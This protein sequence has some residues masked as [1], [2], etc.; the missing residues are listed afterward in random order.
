MESSTVNPRAFVSNSDEEIVISG[1]SGRFP[2]A[3][4][5]YE[6]SHNLYNKI[7]MVDDEETRWRHA[8][9]E[10]PKLSGKISGLER[11]DNNFFGIPSKQ[12]QSMDPQCRMM[13]E[14]A[15]EA[16]LDS[17]T[18]PI[19]IRGTKTGV[20]VG[21]CYSESEKT[22]FYEKATPDGS[23]LSG[24]SRALLA[25]RISFVLGLTGP[26]LICDT[27]CSSS[28][29]ALDM[30]YN[31]IKCG[32]CDA[33]FVGGTNLVL[34]P[35]ISLQFARLGVL[36]M[37]G[38]CSPFDEKASGYT[39]SETTAII[40]LQKM[41]NARR[42]YGTLMYSKSNC[43][44]FKEEGIHYPSGNVQLKL[45]DEFYKDLNIS[46]SSVD[47]IEAHCTG[48]VAGDPE[49]C[50]A[51]SEIFCKD[52]KKPKL[53]GSIKSNLGHTEASSG[54]CSIVKVITIFENGKIP[55][56]INYNSPRID[57]PSL[58][59]GQLKV[60]DEVTDFNGSLICVNSFGFGGANSHALFKKNP[61]SKVNFGIPNDDIPRLV[62]WSG[63]TEEAVNEI[64]DSITEKPLDAE[65]IALLQHSQTKT[66]SANFYK[67]YGIFTNE[68]LKNAN[69]VFRDI[70]HF[71][72][73]KRPMVWIYSGMG[74]QWCGMG[75]DLMK[76]PIFADAIEKCH[77]VLATKGMN[78][79]EIITS[80]DPKTFENILHS[81][82][83]I[84]AIQIGLTDVL[85]TLGL[86]PDFVIGH[87]VG[88]LGCA[89]A[90]NCF[91]AEE[92]ILSA[93]SR[94]MASLE[95]KVVRGSMAAVGLGYN[96]LKS[97]LPDDIEIAC[98]NSFESCTISGPSENVSKFVDELMTKGIFAKEVQCSN[99]AY[100]S[101]YIA[102][103]GSNLLKRLSE[104][105]KE[106]KKR[107]S[108]WISTSYPKSMWHLEKSQY[109]SA[110][111]HTN[112]LLSSVLFEESS[113]LLPKNAVCIEIAPHGLLQA[114]VK[115][116]MNNAI[117]IPL[118]HRG[119]KNNDQFLLNALGK[120]FC[121]GYDLNLPLLYPAVNFPV[122]RGTPMISPR[123]KWDHSDTWYVAN[124]IE[125][126]TLDKSAERVVK[127]NL[128]DPEYEFITG[129]MIDGRCLFP[130][131]GYLYLVWETFS[132]I[133]G[134]VAQKS[135]VEFEDVKFLRATNINKQSE[136]VFT[137]VIQP[138]TGRFEICE[139]STEL[140][141]GTIRLLEKSNH[142]KFNV[143]V[144][145][146][147]LLSSADFY[148]E[149]RLR[150]YH[151]NGEFKSVEESNYDGTYGRIRWRGNW[152]AFMDCMLQLQIIGKDTRSLVLPTSIQKLTINLTECVFNKVEDEDQFFD[153]YA[154]KELK[155]IVGGSVKIVGLK[156]SVVHRR[157]A[158]GVPVLESYQFIPHNPTPIL[159]K[160]D[161][162]RVI[163]QL[164]LENQPDSLVKV[165]EV[166]GHRKMLLTE[167]RDGLSDL[168]LVTPDLTLISSRNVEPEDQIVVENVKLSSQK[169]CLIVILSDITNNFNLIE[170][171]KAA[172]IDGGFLIC[173]ESTNFRHQNEFKNLLSIATIC[174][175]DE[176]LN[177][178]HYKK[179]QNVKPLT[180]IY[181]SEKDKSFDWIEETKSLMKNGPLVLVSQ[182][183]PCNGLLGLVNCMRKEPEGLSIRCVIIDDLKA[184][185]F[186]LDDP[187]Y[188][189]QLNLDLGINIYREGQWGTYRH[190]QITK[191]YSEHMTLDHCYANA[192]V[193]SD[194]SSLKWL[195]GPLNFLS[196]KNLVRVHYS[197]L[198]FK[199]V[200]MATGKINAETFVEHRL[201]CECVL[202]FEYSGVTREGRRVMGLITSGAL[203]TF[204]DSDPALMWDVPKNWTLE[205]AATV[206]CV[207]GTVYYAFFEKAK[208]Q[209]G[210]SIL[211]HS[212][213]GGIGLAAIRV[214][215]AYGL[216]VFTTV[217]TKEKKEFLLKEFPKLKE[218]NIGNSRDI[219]FEEMIMVQ[220]DGKGV[221][222]VLNSLAEEKLL[223]SLRCLK[224]GGH[225]MEIGKYD[226]EKDTKIGMG[227][228]LQE[229]SV[230]S[231]H[232][233]KVLCA[234]Y[235]D[236]MKLRNLFEK[237]LKDSV[238]KPLNANVYKASKI[239]QAFR[240]MSTG[241]HIGKILLQIRST[242]NEPQTF[243]ITV[244]PRVY[245]NPEHS[246][247]ISGGLGGFGL[248]LADWLVL[249]GCRKLVLS[250]SRGIT[251]QYQAY[252]IKIWESYGVNVAINT[253]DITTRS[254]CEQLIKEAMKLGP[255]GGIFN[256]AVLLRDAIFEN[257]DSKSFVES[258]GPKAIATKYLD[259]LSR[260]LCPE[261]QYFVVFSS[262][263]CG[264]GNA[265]QTNYGM[266]NSVMER[267]MEQRYKFG[268][269]AKAIQ[270]GA[271]GEVGLVADMQE[272]HKIDME[273][274]GTLQQRISSC[275]EELDPLILDLQSVVSSMVVAEKKSSGISK[276][277]IVETVM[278][279]M[280]IRDIKSIS[281]ETTLSEMGMDSLMAVELKQIFDREF[282][283]NFSMQELRTLNFLKIM[284]IAQ[285][286]E[287]DAG[288]DLSNDRKPN[289]NIFESILKHLSNALGNEE[290]IQYYNNENISENSDSVGLI[291]PGMEGTASNIMLDLFKNLKFSYFI[292]NYSS[293]EASK[294]ETIDELMEIIGVDTINALQKY[295][296]IFIIA[297]SFGNF[298]AIKLAKFFESVGKEIFIANVDGSPSVLSKAVSLHLENKN[299]KDFYDSVLCYTAT[300]ITQNVDKEELDAITKEDTWENKLNKFFE[301]VSSQKTFRKETLRVTMKSVVNR[302]LIMKNDAEK[303]EVLKNTKCALIKPSE[304][305]IAN[306]KDNY[307]LDKYFKQE[308]KI[309]NL[310]GDHNSILENEKLPQILND[311]YEE[312]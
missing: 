74:S 153:I 119:H 194:L 50:K 282:D 156:A 93:Y 285:S 132:M 177:V 255:V 226:I 284:E 41:K 304:E 166:E 220:T 21:V 121:N 122:S 154:S 52:V 234:P 216:E 44:G 208:I 212:G 104:V 129:H 222:Y 244:H 20:F 224:F 42:N 63:R 250:S 139:G 273:I 265:G 225:F 257:Q 260:T 175:E 67:G 236:R 219:S 146:K 274:G 294:A 6:L 69:C 98:H 213:S 238:V 190:L 70:Q 211:I 191:S 116:S 51:I 47:Y 18:N 143:K 183:E 233:D 262:V 231:I 24:N 163:V 7:N 145:R 206:P 278:N 60:V 76:I 148:K 123:I 189:K 43:D 13:L 169:K 305:I 110:D 88:E 91:T 140:V 12:A 127:I 210:K 298:L 57:I 174:T 228:F 187:F 308:V 85:K 245:C 286:R 36:S 243:P 111:Y 239:E 195:Q 198:N 118:T 152:V 99:I 256:L 217:S 288:E 295:N 306:Q 53:I 78:L 71:S 237:G 218:S 89:Y 157:R 124:G 230:H 287:S 207:Y 172:L 293:V 10:I 279:I 209:K 147:K 114:I 29:T 14:H 55:P 307:D 247:I 196:S 188:Q 221:D 254:G 160:S 200:M 95:T 199:D 309:I 82:V 138:G 80:K 253:S 197:S 249:R 280:G 68:G 56:N 34:H 61:K 158:P 105:I 134:S 215:L 204:V 141:T 171:A 168:P 165:V 137:I 102:Q 264:R 205:E 49:E 277:N 126:K 232:L 108:K 142:P 59:N 248:E 84:A 144:C 35:L 155:T 27:A 87:S 202:G 2:R 261:L 103:M 3:R 94:G 311:L 101:K 81:F 48:T 11:F 150:G 258:M 40:F 115:R 120:I 130:A 176:N 149:L 203:A 19:S 117:H 159:S 283:I 100:H 17:G 193:K 161:A 252:R 299:E 170:E 227:N 223:A 30:A 263:S 235:E 109:S 173:R 32:E 135:N 90:D 77:A 16:V 73:L 182:N 259:E 179:Q 241:K 240:F 269:P 4:N 296:K 151:Y 268:L 28:M 297:H 26:S 302:I 275:L 164:A 251:K 292:L 272:D 39:R 92:M 133:V 271:V 184:P 186:S 45:L 276:G 128:N 214:A 266:A 185:K 289:A 58:H 270:W 167:I 86:Q 178:F 96:Q 9:S 79:K 66:V 125:E 83:G 97:I 64:L 65:Y 8:N 229:I 181:I 290:K 33:A 25:N 112:N 136:V 31:A 22:W 37:S 162:S 46:P 23:G 38:Y 180:A 312:F 54:L 62:I 246:Y 5:L 1:V 131:T 113:A 72:G 300:I 281:L 107:S 291:I 301:C 106:P 15:Y 201:Q 267:I 242:E 192:T 310:E 303:L 75:A